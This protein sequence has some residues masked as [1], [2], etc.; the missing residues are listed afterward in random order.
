MLGG[1]L[2]A[3][4]CDNDG[5]VYDIGV[6]VKSQIQFIVTRGSKKFKVG[7]GLVLGWVGGLGGGVGGRQ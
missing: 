2:I 6:S 4:L 5:R 7:L 1:I 3:K